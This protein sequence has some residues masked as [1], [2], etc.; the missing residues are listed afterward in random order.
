MP[1][2][3]P[4]LIYSTAKVQGWWIV[5]W[6]AAQSTPVLRASVA[7]I[8]SLLSAGTLTVPQATVIPVSDYRDA[9]RIADGEAGDKK[10]LVRF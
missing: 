6:A 7:E 3:S 4:R 2:F 1:I 8:L 5:R 9:L 10:I